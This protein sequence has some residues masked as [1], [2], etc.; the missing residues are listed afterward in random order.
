MGVFHGRS[1]GQK[2]K[3]R[4]YEAGKHSK[5]FKKRKEEVKQALKSLGKQVQ[6][7]DNVIGNQEKLSDKILLWMTPGPEASN[8]VLGEEPAILFPDSDDLDVL[9]LETKKAFWHHLAIET[10]QRDA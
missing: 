7:L 9:K 10:S 8:Q 1:R 4:K 5:G 2:G 6:H 3:K